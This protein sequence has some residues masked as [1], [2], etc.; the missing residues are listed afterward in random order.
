MSV[1]IAICASGWLLGWWAFGRVRFL[2]EVSD[3]PSELG[4]TIVIP[5]RNEALS[6]PNLLAD[7]DEHRPL[8]ARVVV[9]DDHS[10]DGTGELAAAF[11]FVEVIEAPPLPDGWTG[12]SWA[13]HTGAAAA[14]GD[15]IVFLDADVRVTAGSMDRLLSQVAERGGLVSVQP[16][17]RT[18][19]AY[20]QCSALFNTIAV[21]GAGAG[22]R[23]GPSGAFGPVLATTLADYRTAGGHES[24]RAEVVEDLA[25][26][27][28]Y[29]ITR[30]PV[31]VM[32][33][34]RS[35]R[36]RMYPAGIRQLA[37]GWTKN[38]ASGASSTGLARLGAVFLWITSLGSSSITLVD[39]ARGNVPL[40]IA[41]GIYA[42]FVVQLVVLFRLVGRF[43]VL[44]ALC[45]PALFVVFCGIFVRS[46]WRTHVRRSVQWRDRQISLGPARS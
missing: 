30:L 1:T 39:A 37:E 2:S 5:A 6:L 15:A 18:E 9:V 25:L 26:A 28:R 38:F 7:L 19:R 43:G 20:E 8:G 32:L 16:W 46:L 12:K 41:G 21:M 33:G 45:Y 24:V 17:H 14:T 3:Q 34:G 27:R 44:T 42:L 29:R 4:V 35:I 11:D 36:F 13:C 23:G 22:A 40:A 10:T 31:H